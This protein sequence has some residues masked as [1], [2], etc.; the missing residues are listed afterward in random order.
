MAEMRSVLNCK[1]E[2]NAENNEKQ[3]KVQIYLSSV[4]TFPALVIFI[5]VN[6]TAYNLLIALPVVVAGSMFLTF[7]KGK[8]TRW[9][10]L[11]FR[12]VD[13]PIFEY[14]K[15]DLPFTV[16]NLASTVFYAVAL[17]YLNIYYKTYAE[18]V[19]FAV[20]YFILILGAIFI[21]RP[22]QSSLSTKILNSDLTERFNNYS[23]KLGF[24]NIRIYSVPWTRFKTANA[25][26]MGGA[27]NFY[28]YV[29]D[30]L[31]DNLDPDEIDYVILHE[32]F[33]A[34][35]KHILKLIFYASLMLFLLMSMKLIP[36]SLI[37]NPMIEIIAFMGYLFSILGFMP[38]LIAYAGRKYETEA[39]LYAVRFSKNPHAASS[40]LRKLSKLNMI[41]ADYTR[42]RLL[43]THPSI[44]ERIRIINEA[45]E[46][47]TAD[48]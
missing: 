5:A 31:L 13:V 37:G 44:N 10:D 35:R 30:Y 9:Y 8:L 22:L 16:T 11:R 12:L 7:L 14:L 23:R 15:K 18:F 33:H 45:F 42:Y 40:A 21:L 2:P 17:H 1:S 25:F 34:N 46:N 36:F 27:L 32:L 3:E 26:Q 41:P 48:V 29:T 47:S 24:R 39:D 38:F 43:K 20:F 19:A 28:V 4:Y 6:F